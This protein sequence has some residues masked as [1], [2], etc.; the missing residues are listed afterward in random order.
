MKECEW[1]AWSIV[2]FVRTRTSLSS[3]NTWKN[4]LCYSIF[5]F[6]CCCSFLCLFATAI[7]PNVGGK[8]YCTLWDKMS[9]WQQ[10]IH[11]SPV[12]NSEWQI[13]FFYFRK[14]Q[15]NYENITFWKILKIQVK[16]KKSEFF[17]SSILTLGS[18]SDMRLCN[19]STCFCCRSTS[20]SASDFSFFFFA[21]FAAFC[22]ARDNVYI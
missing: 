6:C 18:L 15:A 11:R 8:L 7:N 20:F 13:I 17:S 16:T 12:L 5:G 19:L 3:K 2:C 10:I 9:V 4:F 1:I 14:F 21:S 22:S